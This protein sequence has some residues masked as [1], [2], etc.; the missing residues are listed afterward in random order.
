MNLFHET[1]ISFISSLVNADFYPV[2]DGV[3]KNQNS[4]YKCNQKLT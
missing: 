4:Q 2:T 1:V 3:T